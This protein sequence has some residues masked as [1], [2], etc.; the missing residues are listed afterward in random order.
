MDTGKSLR[1]RE[2]NIEGFCLIAKSCA[3]IE[4]FPFFGT[5]LGITR[6]N[7]LIALDDDV[8]FYVCVSERKRLEEVL[9]KL[10][11]TVDMSLERNHSPYFLQASVIVDGEEVLID[12]YFYEPHPGHSFITDWWN[13]SGSWQDP[14]NEMR[15]PKDIVFPL[16]KKSLFEVEFLLPSSPELC[17]RFLYGAGWNKPL[18]KGSQYFISIDEYAP[19]IWMNDAY[20]VAVQDE[21]EK[22]R[23]N[24]FSTER[25]L[26]EITGSLSWKLTAPLRSVQ[27]WFKR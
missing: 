24:L 15:I 19:K 17:C 9:S 25:H 13:F 4:M 8:D 23:T 12:F 2:R 10:P 3:D 27:S 20:V 11:V 7:N 1:N 16:Q 18:S 26:A 14:R 22:V 21:L 5:L 6:E